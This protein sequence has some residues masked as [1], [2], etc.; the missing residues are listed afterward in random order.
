MYGTRAFNPTG[1]TVLVSGSISP[2]ALQV[3]SVG[4]PPANNYRIHNA[5]TDTVYIAFGVD[6]STAAANAVI[7]TGSGANAKNSYPLPTGAVEVFTALQNCYWA[8]RI[9]AGTASVF[10]TP[11]AGL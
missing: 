5:G 6:A 2:V 8:A 7:P 11:G 1:P 3:L 4:A 9:A 10:V